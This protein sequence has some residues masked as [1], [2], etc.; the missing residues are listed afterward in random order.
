MTNY[1]EVIRIIK[2]DA[3]R[4]ETEYKNRL[5]YQLKRFA[6]DT[7]DFRSIMEN[8][9]ENTDTAEIAMC[10]LDTIDDIFKAL[11]K[12]DINIG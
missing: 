2:A 7:A 10:L 5:A 4:R 1:E 9:D 12:N 6:E 3:E 8:R 11:S